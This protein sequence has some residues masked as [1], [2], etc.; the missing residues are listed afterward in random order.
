MKIKVFYPNENGK[1]EFTKQELEKLLDEAYKE[2]YS[3]SDNKYNHPWTISTPV[4]RDK[5]SVNSIELARN[6]E[7]QINLY[8][9]RM[10]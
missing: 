8:D 5:S 2:G 3:D 6:L 4:Y 7:G 1:I 9:S 10:D